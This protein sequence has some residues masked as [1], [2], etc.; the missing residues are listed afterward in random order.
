MGLSRPTARELSSTV[1]VV[2][3]R[4]MSGP[5]AFHH[6]HAPP[7]ALRTAPAIIT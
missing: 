2:H 4:A 1:R 7:P 5:F 3:G 6:R